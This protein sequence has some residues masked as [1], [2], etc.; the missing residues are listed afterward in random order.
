M[1][2]EGD[3]SMR[4]CVRDASVGLHV[5]PVGAVLSVGDVFISGGRGSY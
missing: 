2:R 3:D 4:V 1:S 5:V